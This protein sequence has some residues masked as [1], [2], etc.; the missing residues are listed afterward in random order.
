MVNKQ[1]DQILNL[2]LLDEYKARIAIDT[3]NEAHTRAKTSLKMFM[4]EHGLGSVSRILDIELVMPLPQ[5]ILENLDMDTDSDDTEWA[6]PTDSI[7]KYIGEDGVYRNWLTKP[8]HELF[9]PRNRK[10]TNDTPW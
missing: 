2:L 5:D 3:A 1:A 9:H 7:L 4:R 10:V 8:E 6:I